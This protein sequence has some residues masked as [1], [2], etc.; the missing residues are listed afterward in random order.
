MGWKCS[1]QTGNQHEFNFRGPSSDR[2]GFCAQRTYR[3][4]SSISCVWSGG[5]NFTTKR[6]MVFLGPEGEKWWDLVS[7]KTEKQ[8]QRLQMLC[9]NVIFIVL[10]ESSQEKPLRATYVWSASA[11]ASG[12]PATPVEGKKKKKKSALAM[13]LSAMKTLFFFF[14]KKMFEPGVKMIY[15]QVIMLLI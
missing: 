10:S 4:S 7:R 11:W 12:D 9:F 6:R 14:L 3:V 13:L 8:L 15:F 1:S 2:W 5:K